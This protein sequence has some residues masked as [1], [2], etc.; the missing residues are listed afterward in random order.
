MRTLASL[1]VSVNLPPSIGTSTVVD[2]VV[3]EPDGTVATRSW[4]FAKPW[5]P[6][7]TVM[8][9]GRHAPPAVISTVAVV[10]SPGTLLSVT[11]PA[12]AG[13]S[14]MLSTSPTTAAAGEAV[15]AADVR[16]RVAAAAAAVARIRA[17]RG[18]RKAVCCKRYSWSEGSR[19]IP[20]HV[21]PRGRRARRATGCRRLPPHRAD[22]LVDAL[23]GGR[24]LTE[25]RSS[26]ANPGAV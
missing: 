24:A 4:Q 26:G 22:V 6:A 17:I 9:V 16:V 11:V 23:C 20:G 13:R 8:S 18:A 12:L 7:Q 2:S 14:T 21:P 5:E 15:T 19:P 25:V 1:L 3:P 10:A